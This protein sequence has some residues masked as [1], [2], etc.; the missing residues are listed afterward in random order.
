MK[1][2][3]DPMLLSLGE[4]DDIETFESIWNEET[5]EFVT[6]DSEGTVEGWQFADRLALFSG[7]EYSHGS[8]VPIL[9]C[10]YFMMLL[11]GSWNLQT[12]FVVY[13]CNKCSKGTVA[14]TRK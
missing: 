13:A 10:L 2:Q 3:L 7:K 1:E 5:L 4:N 8:S 11:A 14:W 12:F 9:F 6:F